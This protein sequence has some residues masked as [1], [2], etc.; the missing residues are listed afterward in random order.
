MSI[1]PL[2]AEKENQMR[3]ERN[4]NKK[5]SLLSSSFFATLRL[6]TLFEHFFFEDNK[7]RVAVCW[8]SVS[9]FRIAPP[10]PTT[11]HKLTHAPYLAMIIEHLIK[12]SHSLHFL[13]LDKFLS[14]SS[15]FSPQSSEP[16]SQTMNE[17]NWFESQL[18]WLF[19][20]WSLSLLMV[21]RASDETVWSC[22]SPI[23]GSW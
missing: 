11:T 19:V 18:Y 3:S 6:S 14:H 23:S 1:F 20:L 9:P 13:T 8:F 2:K 21:S 4:D 12:G 17:L 22:S 16:P 7:S 10:K 5:K 15:S